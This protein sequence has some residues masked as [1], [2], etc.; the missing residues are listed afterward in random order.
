MS[1]DYLDME[2]QVVPKVTVDE[3]TAK[4]G[5]DKD[6]VTLTFIVKSKLAGEDLVSWFERGYDYVLDASVS[7]G[8]ISPNKYLVFVEMKRR[9]TVPERI[10]ELLT[11]LETLTGLKTTDYTISIDDEDYDATE[12]ILKQKIITSPLEY[13]KT[14]EKEEELNEFRNL[15]GL[16]SKKLYDEDSYIK[17]VKAMAGL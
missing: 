9:T 5:S 10:I 6:I 14:K 4:M 2:G 12:E 13:K 7:D 17:N 3:Y 11:D 8:E 1:L 16:E 15:S